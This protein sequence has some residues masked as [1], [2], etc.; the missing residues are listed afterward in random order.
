VIAANMP[1]QPGAPMLYLATQNQ[2]TIYWDEV[3]SGG[4]AITSYN[5]FMAATGTSSGRMLATV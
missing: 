2:I 4:S 3:Y 5:I 1:G